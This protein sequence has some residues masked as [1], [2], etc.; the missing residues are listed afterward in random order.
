MLH[1]QVTDGLAPV[2]NTLTLT[3]QG[4]TAEI[5]VFSAN[6]GPHG[7]ELWATDGTGVGMLKDVVPGG[8]S[9][10]PSGFTVLGDKLIFQTPDPNG[11]T[12]LWAT[13]GTTAGTVP[14][15][16]HLGSKPPRPTSQCLA[17]S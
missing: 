2:D 15:T 10:N 5:V 9:S 1:Y 12:Q 17:T 7:T 3:V 16:A 8:K 4:D 6:D 13:D 11:D 14:L